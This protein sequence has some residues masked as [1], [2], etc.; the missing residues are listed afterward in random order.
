MN[1]FEIG[2]VLV[3]IGKPI[4]WVVWLTDSYNYHLN[5][6]DQLLDNVFVPSVMSLPKDSV[7]ACFVK[8]GRWDWKECKEIFDNDPL[9]I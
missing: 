7:N 6:C 9:D 4:K 2:D 8:I 3:E 1:E 5:P